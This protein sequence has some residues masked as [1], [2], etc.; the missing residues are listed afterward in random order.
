M[1][2]Y[3]VFCKFYDQMKVKSNGLDLNVIYFPFHFIAKQI[4]TQES[5]QEKTPSVINTLTSGLNSRARNTNL[6]LHKL[7]HWKRESS[8]EGEDLCLP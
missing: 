2:H 8:S 1:T 3:I 5:S 4:Q 6:S 7:N